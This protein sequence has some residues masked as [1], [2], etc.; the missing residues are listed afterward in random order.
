MSCCSTI[1]DTHKQKEFKA[2]V[3]AVLYVYFEI[4][5]HRAIQI[6]GYETMTPKVLETAMLYELTHE[7]ALFQKSQMFFASF[8]LDILDEETPRISYEYTKCLNNAYLYAKYALDLTTVEDFESII[9]DSVL[10][11]VDLDHI[12]QNKIKI[13]PQNVHILPTKLS[14][15][16]ITRIDTQYLELIHKNELSWAPTTDIEHILY[17][18]MGF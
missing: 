18:A 13:T 10:N 7:N 3:Y 17:S 4:S 14:P 1:N 9:L 12:L 6:S 2:R 15:I 8:L 11:F 5:L 16:P